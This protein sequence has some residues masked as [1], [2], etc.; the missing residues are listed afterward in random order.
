[1]VDV[2]EIVLRGDASG[3][4]GRAAGEAG[5]VSNGVGGYP[6]AC[7]VVCAFLDAVQDILC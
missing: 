2:H 3:H 4:E 5:A 7:C 1:M 6:A